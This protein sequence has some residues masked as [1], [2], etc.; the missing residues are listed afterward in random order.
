MKGEVRLSV[1][2]LRKRFGRR[3]VLQE[4]HLELLAGEVLLLCGPNGAGKSTLLRILAGLERPD[5]AL[6]DLGTGMLPWRRHRDS[7]FKNTLYL[8]QHPYMFDA[9]VRYNLA[10]ALPR[11]VNGEARHA[12]IAQ[13]MSWAGLEHL[14]DSASKN[15]SGGERQR[16]SLAR[17]W[18]RKPRIL[19]LDEPTANLD[20]ESRQRTLE[21]LA[22]FKQSGMSMIIASHDTHHF[23]S[24]AD[25]SLHL[26]EGQ[27]IETDS[28]QSRPL[29]ATSNVVSLGS[30]A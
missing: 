22:P 15:L 7:L 8:H 26:Q 28:G 30:T 4:I 14:Q 10:Y 13:A 5:H 6:I 12:Q 19:F 24:L 23:A 18:L 20:Q 27:L 17:A 9:S 3:Q 2:A 16:V 21:L 29:S 25:R 1:D 11:R